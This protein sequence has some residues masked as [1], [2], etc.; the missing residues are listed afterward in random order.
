VGSYALHGN[1]N[2]TP[3]AGACATIDL[4]A[5]GVQVDDEVKIEID[6]RHVGSGGNWA[7]SHGNQPD[8]SLSLIDVDEKTNAET[9][10]ETIV[11]EFTATV[12]TRY[13]GFREASGA[14]DGGF[15]AD[16]LSVKVK[17]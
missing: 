8:F 7:F 15:Y 10:F 9:T 1:S 2:D 12:H 17:V 3:T 13:F 5:L 11:H 6:W 16:N 4:E 14:N